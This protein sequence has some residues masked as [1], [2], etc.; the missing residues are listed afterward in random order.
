MAEE[1][2]KQSSVDHGA[3]EET[4][5]DG[6]NVST[7]PGWREI[8][9]QAFDKARQQ[10]QPRSR[11]ELGRDKSRSLFL[12]AGA[13]IALL[14]L[15]LGVFSSS[16]TKKAT[17]GRPPGA[18]DLGR[19][20]TPG[21]QRHGEAGSLTPLLNAQ[22]GQQDVAADQDVTAEEVGRTARHSQ[23]V[24][25]SQPVITTNPSPAGP[26]A[27][28]RINFSDTVPHQE[29]I[30][31]TAASLRTAS[32]DLRKPSLVFVRNIQSNAVS[33]GATLTSGAM[34]ES[35]ITVNL[36]AGTRL[37]ARLQSVVNSAVK[38]PV[39]AAIEYNYERDG[40]IIVP[41]GVQVLGSLQQADKSG[42][43]AIRFDTIQMP[44]GSTEK[45]DATAMSLT[46]GP[47]KG[48]VNGKRT[49]TNF[50]VRTFTG[51]GQ[52]ATYLVGSNGLNAP[53][54][55]SAF[56]RD[57]IATN[58]G[59][60]GD[61][62][63]NSLAFNQNIV[64]TVPGN[65]RFYVVIEK[66]ATVRDEQVRPAGTQQVNNGPLPTAEELRQLMQL[67]RELSELYQQP[68]TQDTA[69]QVPQQ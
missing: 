19:R 15:F 1:N 48:V 59:I 58:I 54:S 33:P 66:G 18:P 27:L 63:L 11:R 9:H 8:F 16:N 52:A 20:M 25:A 12:L 24:P 47:L 35:P 22:G 65:T 37:V 60:A 50:L 4:Q 49:G 44:D 64:V 29:T 21:Q 3:L 41:A 6:T 14:L 61:Q 62:Q 56:L 46:F 7:R 31:P 68:S 10:Q 69:Q 45:I 28:G 5:A 51:L 30:T 55:E 23:S 32:D 2:E 67:R 40:E 39:V 26:Y 53:L 43:V 38:T 57:R 34:Q 13:A 17:S 36:P 42:Y